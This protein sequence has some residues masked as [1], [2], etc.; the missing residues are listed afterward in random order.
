MVCH[1][2]IDAA[3]LD[4]VDAVVLVSN[5]EERHAGGDGARLHEAT[6]LQEERLLKVTQNPARVNTVSMDRF[7]QP[8]VISL[9]VYTFLF[10]P[11]YLGHVSREWKPFIRTS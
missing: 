1:V 5:T 10:L 11:R 3:S 6:Q 4:D 2:D 8:T 7:T 9:N